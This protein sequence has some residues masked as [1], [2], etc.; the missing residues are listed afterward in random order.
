MTKLPI[1][2]GHSPQAFRGF[3]RLDANYIYCPNQFFE[4]CLRHYSRGIVR[5]VAFV[6][7]K[8]LGYLD[9]NGNPVRQDIRVSY[10]DLSTH[11]GVSTR[12]IPKALEDAESG[13]FI[14]C[15]TPGVPNSRGQCGRAAE[16][17]LRW[18]DEN[19]GYTDDPQQFRGFYAGDGHRSP[20]PNGFFDIVVRQ[21]PLAMA[22]VVGTVLRHTVG[23]QNQFGGRRSDAPLSYSYM[24]RFA[25]IGDRTTLSQTLKDATQKGYVCCVSKGHFDP[26]AGRQSRSAQY[27]VKWLDGAE[28]LDG[29]AKTRPGESEHGKKPTGNTAKARPG[30]DGKNPTDRKTVSKTSYK[31]QNV[32][33]TNSEGCELLIGEGINKTTAITLAASVTLEEIRNQIKWLEFR[34]PANRPAMLRK[35]IEERWCEPDG[36]GEHRNQE[37]ARSREER[38]NV[39]RAVHEIAIAGQK[40]E[41]L[42]RRTRLLACWR[43]QSTENQRQFRQTAAE[44]AA[45]EFQRRLIQKSSLDSPVGEVLEAMAFAVA[46][47]IGESS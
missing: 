34:N 9:E 26:N 19:T 45:T 25:N 42:Q 46:E 15:V 21:D 16:Y 17:Q 23:Y 6:L 38:E 40:Q 12:A 5:L 28:R 37:H 41:R 4:V 10:S 14:Q 43:Q 7:R 1:S 24:Q 30:K 35:A 32:V 18:S 31:Q 29:T 47:P 27:A 33:A 2:T 39:E 8:T 11:A 20:I 44:Q 3:E 36:I 13:R 22:K